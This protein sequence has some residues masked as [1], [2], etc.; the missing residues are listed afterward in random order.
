M[1]NLF[2]LFFIFLFVYK[3]LNG[4]AQEE[5]D[6]KR[7][8]FKDDNRKEMTISF[9]FINNLIII[10]LS[11]NNSDSLYFILDTGLR[12]TVLTNLPT[13][14]NVIFNKVKETL[15]SGLGEED[16]SK[17]WITYNNKVEINN[18]TS[19][20]VTIYVLEHDRFNLSS[21]MG[22][23][24]NGII[25]NDIFENFIIKIDYL[26]QK[27]TFADPD[28]FN[29]SKK[30]DKWVEYSI[31]LYNK[32]PYIELPVVLQN[33]SLI[34][35][36]LLLDNGSSDA[37]WLFPYTNPNIQYP[38]ESESFYLGQGLNGNI[39]GKQGHIKGLDIG[40]RTLK[41]VT[42][43]FPDSLSV[44][45]AIMNDVPGRN[46]SIGTEVL[47]RFHLIIDYPNLKV[48]MKP[49]ANFDDKFYFNLSGLEVITPYLGLPIYEISQVRKNSPSDI[50]KVQIGDQIMEI[51][52][53][54]VI[55]YTLNDIIAILKNSSCKKL[56]LKLNRNGE[57]ITVNIM[58]Y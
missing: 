45:Y 21:Q 5:G 33:D 9:R 6:G 20:N 32:K 56:K 34:T 15:I 43:S 18:I 47:R 2:Y 31:T 7:F 50:A 35:A 49:N 53:T 29:Y 11:I 25:G 39:Y 28:K 10:P 24:I 38:T 54:E 27:I 42:A 44:R 13:D 30:Y 8:Y 37:L 1:K 40:N 17:A 46:G 55:E 48:L 3:P 16:D 22:T 57:I 14:K 51:N 26:R 36:K 12:F 58:L 19:E 4:Y 52:N 41:D 23:E